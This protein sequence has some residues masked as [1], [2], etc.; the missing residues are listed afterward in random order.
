MLGTQRWAGHGGGGASEKVYKYELAPEARGPAAAGPLP[1]T[2]AG[3]ALNSGF[4]G[5]NGAPG[6]Q[7]PPEAVPGDEA[8]AL[9]GFGAPRAGQGPGKERGQL[10]SCFG[11]VRV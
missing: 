4:Q 3:G 10:R 8:V 1:L 11:P 7:E 6:A 5:P 2:P 9:A